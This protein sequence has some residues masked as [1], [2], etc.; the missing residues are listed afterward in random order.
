MRFFW[1]EYDYLYGEILVR[2]D[3][4]DFARKLDM[5]AVGGGQKDGRLNLSDSFCLVFPFDKLHFSPSLT[6]LPSGTLV[7]KAGVTAWHVC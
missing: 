5:R 4:Y 2:S 7:A 6:A 3:L 1:R